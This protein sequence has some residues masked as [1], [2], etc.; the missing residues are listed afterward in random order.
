VEVF[1]GFA[2]LFRLR[3]PTSASAAFRC[4]L[5]RSSC[6]RILNLV[7]A[8][9]D[10]PAGSGGANLVG[11][12]M[13]FEMAMSRTEAGSRPTRLAAVAMRSRTFV[14]R[15][16]SAAEFGR[17]YLTIFC[18]SSA[19]TAFAVG[20]LLPFRR[21]LQVG[22][23]FGLR[24]LRV[25]GGQREAEQIVRVGVIR[26]RLGDLFQQRFASAILP[27]LK[28][29]AAWLY[30]ASG[31]PLLPRRLASRRR[32]KP[33]PCR[34]SPPPARTLLRVVDRGEAVVRLDVVRVQLER[35]L[36]VVSAFG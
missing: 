20:A 29:L 30:N 14:S 33:R 12:K 5:R 8:E 23:D 16:R 36:E 35:L 7:L 19:H 17:N 25:V 3:W 21:E 13:F 24:L 22:F 1:G 18:S 31:L 11:G 4:R 6:Q 32:T 2:C 10:L 27:A 28:R 34:S 26:G 9:V 15:A